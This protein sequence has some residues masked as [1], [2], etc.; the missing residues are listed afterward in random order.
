MDKLKQIVEKC[1]AGVHLTVNQHRD[2]YETV[3]H[4]LADEYRGKPDAIISPIDP[5]KD[6][7]ELQ[8]YPDTPVGFYQGISNDP[9]ELLD[10]ALKILEAP[11]RD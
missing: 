5:E 3:E 1:K 8:F 2:Y 7:W 10:W 11:N 9:E 4:Y 6:L